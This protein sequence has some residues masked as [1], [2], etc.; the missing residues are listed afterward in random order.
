MYYNE[1]STET[2]TFGE[3]TIVYTGSFTPNEPPVDN[4]DMR[5]VDIDAY[6]VYRSLTSDTGFEEIAE[7][8]GSTT[9][10]LDLNVVNSTTYYYYVLPT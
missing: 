3:P 4:N 9:Q 6:K 8:S 10:Y 7:V 2:L 5:P 1:F